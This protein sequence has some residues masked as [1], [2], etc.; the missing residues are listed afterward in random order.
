MVGIIGFLLVQG[1]L[2][3]IWG[4]KL[5]DRVNQIEGRGSPQI[6]VI[7]DRLTRVEVQLD[8]TVKALEKNSN[9]LDNLT[10]AIRSK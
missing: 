1:S 3:V 8:T 5:E 6:S 7:S 2:L 10:D 4:V 9:K